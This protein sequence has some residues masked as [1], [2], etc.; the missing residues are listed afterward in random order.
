MT[1]TSSGPTETV[2]DRARRAVRASG[3]SQREFA[4]RIG[5]DPTALSKALRGTR[6]L[7]DVE[8][9]AIAKVGRVP[10][11]FLRSPSVPPPATLLA[12]EERATR[13]RAEPVHAEVRRTQ[14]L[15][16]TARLIAQ[17]GFHHVRVADIARV[18][19]TSP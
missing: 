5:M 3:I 15:E 12:A 13:L 10:L 17:R 4:D 16:A 8:L 19:D 2:A 14:I 6:R 18:C 1:A 11:R 9:A 7:S